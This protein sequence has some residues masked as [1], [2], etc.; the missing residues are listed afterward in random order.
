MIG[1]GGISHLEHLA[2]PLTVRGRDEG[3]VDIVEAVIC[4]ELVCRKGQCRSDSGHGTNGVRAGPQV[5]DVAEEFKGVTL[6]LQG[7]RGVAGPEKVHECGFH[8]DLR[9]KG[10]GWSVGYERALGMHS[11]I[12]GLPIC[13]RSEQ[14]EATRGNT[15]VVCR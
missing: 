5:G 2:S 3:R 11:L 12:C 4:E 8:L 14:T 10:K 7:I 9:A 13:M 1:Q 6:F 15:D